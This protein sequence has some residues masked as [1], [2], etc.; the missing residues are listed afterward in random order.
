MENLREQRTNF[1]EFHLHYFCTILYIFLNFNFTNLSSNWKTTCW[2]HSEKHYK[3]FS[4][5]FT[6]KLSKWHLHTWKRRARDIAWAW[7]WPFYKWP[8]SS[9]PSVLKSKT[10]F[11]TDDSSTKFFH[12]YPVG[13]KHSLF[14]LLV[15]RQEGTLLPGI[16]HHIQDFKVSLQQ[17]FAHYI[18]LN[19]HINHGKHCFCQ[20]VTES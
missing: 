20:I 9:L 14:F 13:K 5:S 1:N 12:T 3:V 7:S 17:N 19:M 10:N 6:K 2:L 8:L 4:Y 18:V 15:E 11:N 16:L